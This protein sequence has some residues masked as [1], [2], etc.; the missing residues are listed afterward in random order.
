MGEEHEDD[1]AAQRGV[2]AREARLPP[3]DE[4]LWGHGECGVR[5]S[6]S[7]LGSP[8]NTALPFQ[9]PLSFSSKTNAEFRQ[10]LSGFRQQKLSEGKVFHKP[11]L[12]RVPESVDWREKGYVTPVKD[13]VRQCRTQ[14]LHLPQGCQEVAGVLALAD[15]G[16]S[17]SESLSVLLL[18]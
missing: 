1:R 3:G 18:V 12:A 4:R 17:V 13:Q 7:S 10:R 8:H 6:A 2:R 5:G 14:A 16:V 11:L 15:W 9:Q